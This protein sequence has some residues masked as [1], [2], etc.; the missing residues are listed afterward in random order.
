MAFIV[1]CSENIL[2]GFSLQK[3]LGSHPLGSVTGFR[4]VLR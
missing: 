1:V 2:D 3:V 4:K